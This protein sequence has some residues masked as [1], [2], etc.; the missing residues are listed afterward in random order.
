[1]RGSQNIIHREENKVERMDENKHAKEL[2]NF[3]QVASPVQ[4]KKETQGSNIEQRINNDHFRNER[5]IGLPREDEGFEGKGLRRH[6]GTHFLEDEIN[7]DEEGGESPRP[8]DAF[9]GFHKFFVSGPILNEGVFV[10][11]LPL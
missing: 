2:K 6:K 10:L 3:F 5:N 1:M 8:H 7:E 9:G 4:H 11:S